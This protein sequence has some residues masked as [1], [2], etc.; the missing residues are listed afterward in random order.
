MLDTF[1]LAVPL[2]SYTELACHVG[3]DLDRAI[4]QEVVHDLRVPL[5]DTRM[6]F[7]RKSQ[8]TEILIK[9]FESERESGKDIRLAFLRALYK[10]PLTVLALPITWTN[11]NVR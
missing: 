7:L 6:I 4:T 10:T 2:F 8:E 9:R 3:D 5:Y 1:D 11:P